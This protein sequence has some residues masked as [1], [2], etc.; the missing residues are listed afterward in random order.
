MMKTKF[1]VMHYKKNV[2]RRARLDP[3]LGDMNINAE[4]Y[5]K[6]D[7]DELSDSIICKY[8]ATSLDLFKERTLGMYE[9]V[10][11]D[12]YKGVTL[13]GLSL[14]IKHIK[15]MEDLLSSDTDV[16]IFLE[17]DVTFH[18]SKEN[19][20]N[21]VRVANEVPWDALFFGGGFDHGLVADRVKGVYK[22]LLLVDHP[23]TNCTSSYAITKGAAKKIL[24]TFTKVCTS[25]DWELN[26]HFK[27]NNL[28]IWH[29]N[30]YLCGQLSTAGV[31]E[32]TL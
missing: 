28:K 14:C 18:G 27:I 20:I 24:S 1:Y 9:E 13:G 12:G 15:C 4:W 6:Y 32:C 25:I 16:G 19:I 3:I 7:K 31:Y 23:A 17:D 29:T 21:C 8:E 2:K 11:Y 30:P 10:D 26:Y 22:N 5:T